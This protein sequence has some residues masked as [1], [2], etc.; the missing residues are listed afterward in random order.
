MN[1]DTHQHWALCAVPDPIDDEALGED[2]IEEAAEVFKSG[3][4]AGGLRWANSTPV[5]SVPT[6][7]TRRRQAGI[8]HG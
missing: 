8:E 1:F 6:V 2:S 7:P 4:L 5:A 3:L